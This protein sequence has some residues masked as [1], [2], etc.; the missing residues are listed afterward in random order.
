M[1]LPSP[2]ALHSFRL[3]RVGV[4]IAFG[5]ALAGSPAKGAAPF[6][7]G[8]VVARTRAFATS[9]GETLWPGYG[10]APF[11][12]LLLD[13]DKEVL[14]CQPGEP[15]GFEAEGVDDATGCPRWTRARTKMPDVLLAAMPLLGPPATIVMGTPE[16]TGR[17]AAAWQRTILHEHFHQWQ[18]SLPDHYARVDK[19]DL[20]G[21]DETGMWMLNFPFPY[22]RPAVVEAYA[23]ASDTLADALDKRGKAGFLPAF[24]RYLAARKQ[25]AGTVSPRDWRYLDL[26]LWQEGTARWT[27]IQLGKIYPD[28]KVQ[29]SAREL[30]KN[31]LAALRKPDMKGQKRELAYAFGAGEAMLM[32]ACGPAWREAYPSVLGHGE[33]LAKARKACR[34]GS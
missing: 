28:Q 23:R 10:S 29:E 26:Q 25:L 9:S 34:R 7:L 18:W 2:R 21:G 12:F 3:M 5:A 11:G 1:G 32:S 6:E 24:D 27:E 16:S 8:P 22:E 15:K 4:W 20:K 19:L 33:L 14:L 31:T 17:S 13:G 30:E